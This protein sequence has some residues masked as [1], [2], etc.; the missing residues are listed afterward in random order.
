MAKTVLATQKQRADIAANWTT[1]NPILQKGEIGVVT[2]TTPMK[3]KIGNGTSNW[4]N[5][6]FI[7]EI[8]NSIITTALGYTPYDA[9]NPNSYISTVTK[10]MVEAALTGIISS[11]SHS[12]EPIISSGTTAQYLR[13]DKT[14]QNLPTT[15]PASD[16][17]SWAKQPTKPTYNNNEIVNTYSTSYGIS[18]L[19]IT[20]SVHLAWLT[21]T[22]DGQQFTLNYSG[23]P[24]EGW[25]QTLYIQNNSNSYNAY[26]VIPNS[27]SYSTNSTLLEVKWRG[28]TRRF[29]VI[30]FDGKFRFIIPT[31]I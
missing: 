1:K 10:A 21:P 17:Y 8:N 20:S 24:I 2:D 5:L 3:V 11:H 27:G 14:W 6:A 30:Y 23:T 22:E 7:N 29:D 25:T 12:Y 16:V 13:G 31:V 19:P 18:N 28:G 15:L 9:A 4:D 26:V